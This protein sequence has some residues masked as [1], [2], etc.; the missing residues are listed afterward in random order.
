MGWDGF[1]RKDRE[2]LWRCF[3]EEGSFVLDSFDTWK[4]LG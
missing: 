4:F 1:Q 3:I 2:V